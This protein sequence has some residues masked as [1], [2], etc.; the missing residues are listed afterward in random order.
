MKF[1]KKLANIGILALSSAALASCAGKDGGE[2]NSH[3][4][5][6][7]SNVAIKG[8]DSVAYFT[9]S[10]PVKGNPNFSYSYKGS[11][12]WFK[13]SK[14]KDLF[15]SNPSKYE[16]QYGGYCAFGVAVPEKKIDI[17][18]EAWNISDGK[19]YLNYTLPTQ[20]RWLDNKEEY[21]TD[22]N[23]IWPTIK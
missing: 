22:A 5:D 20:E 21:I 3:L 18:P 14:N 23:E 17:D 7:V 19:L 4:V 1:N 8:Y 11:S 10:K 2:I 15:K 6:G 13:N 9:D 12:W 16:P